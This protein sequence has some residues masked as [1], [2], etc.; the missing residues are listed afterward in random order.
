[1]ASVN[2]VVATLLVLLVLFYY[3]SYRIVFH[4]YVKYGDKGLFYGLLCCMVLNVLFLYTSVEISRK[5]NE[6]NK[7]DPK[8][9]D[10]GFDIS[11]NIMI[12]GLAVVIACTIAGGYY[13]HKIATEHN[14]NHSIAMVGVPLIVLGSTAITGGIARMIARMRDPYY[15]K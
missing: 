2:T 6:T 7:D 13:G 9:R 14:L 3:A 8:H 4:L 1:M 11:F 12:Y 10:D 5:A 15:K